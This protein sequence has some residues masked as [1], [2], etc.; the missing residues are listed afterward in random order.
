M[1]TIY[2][3]LA[4]AVCAAA[5][6]I[7]VKTENEIKPI[8][9]TMDVNVKVDNA[10]NDKFADERKPQPNGDFA[11]IK[12]MLG[13][14]VA[15]IDS[16]GQLVARDGATDGDKLDIHDANAR[17]NR[18]LA[19]VATETGVAI[20]AVKARRAAQMIERIPEGSGVWYQAADGN[21][22]QK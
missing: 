10:L 19:E 14:H 16:N 13:R 11:K 20:E 8:H 15:G 3:M 17:Y 1:K 6:C 21:W 5:G 22:K 9:I 18:R 2:F 12:D 7:H 4:A